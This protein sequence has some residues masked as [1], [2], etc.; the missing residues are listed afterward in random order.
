MKYPSLPAAGTG[1]DRAWILAG[2][3]LPASLR[4]LTVRQAALPSPEGAVMAAEVLRRSGR[5]DDAAATASRAAST[6]GLDPCDRALLL[7]AE[8]HAYWSL[9][10][11]QQARG[12]YLEAG[13]VSAGES[14]E[15]TVAARLGAARAGR[16]NLD[17]AAGRVA[18]DAL[19]VASAV[20]DPD[21]LADA[22]RENAA[23]ALMRG[24]APA[25]RSL[26][27][28]AARTH[29]RAGD[30]YLGGLARVLRARALSADGNTDAAVD[31]V[32]A[33]VAAGREVGAAELVMTASVY[34]GQFLQRAATP[35]SERWRE[36]VDVLLGALADAADPVTEAELLLPLAHLWIASGEWPAAR[37]A[38]GRYEALYEA[39]GGNAVADANAAKARARLRIAEGGELQYG[40]FRAARTLP[41]LIAGDRLLR[42]AERL[43]RRAR[44]PAGAGSVRQ[45]R[46]M[47]D[48]LAGSRRI[49]PLPK[50]T[51]I[52]PAGLA[53]E[54]GGA[55]ARARDE[56]L[57][58]SAL[59]ARGR[60]RDAATAF[61]ESQ[62]LALSADSTMLA[63]A[64]AARRAE[65]ASDAD[66]RDQ[67]RLGVRDAVRLTERVRG[68][69]GTGSARG[70]LAG[71]LRSHYERAALLAA[72]LGDGDL[73]LEV[74][75]ALRSERL[76]GLVRARAVP[77]D[78]S[79][80]NDVVAALAAVDEEFARRENFGGTLRNAA[81]PGLRG[82]ASPAPGDDAAPALAALDED[83]LAAERDRMRQRLADLT[84]EVFADL[85]DT[86][87]SPWD[88]L[89]G[90]LRC[91]VLSVAP[92][93]VDGSPPV[94]V[95]AWRAPDGASGVGV[96]EATGAVDRLRDR[97]RAAPP[98]SRAL[99]G[100]ADL[101]CL[102]GLVPPAL[103]LSVARSDGPVD[104]VVVPAG[105]TWAVPFCALPL[106]GAGS[107]IVDRCDVTLAASL[108]THAILQDRPDRPAATA[109]AVSYADPDD[110]DIDA[111]V[112]LA[113]L[114]ASPG[115][116]VPLDDP[117]AFRAA[118]STSGGRF[119]LAAAAAHGNLAPGL[120][121]AVVTRTGMAV[122]AAA[123]FLRPAADPPQ[124]LSFA[125]CHGM[126]PPWDD[127][128]E[129]L[130]LALCALSAG[131][132]AVLSGQY[133]VDGATGA[134]AA[135]LAGAY[136][137][138]LRGERPATALA[139]AQRE[140][141]RTLPLS[142][143][144]VLA[145]LGIAP[146]DTPVRTLLAEGA[147][148]GHAAT[149]S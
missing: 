145:V 130:G 22:Q 34:L 127:Q 128:Y 45:Q 13:L 132:E 87:R 129:P 102:A 49:G 76:A 17:A 137:G 109:A 16:I 74:L 110:P 7:L 80:L 53:A 35:D 120:S 14:D 81:V 29:D 30:R 55:L 64:A 96:V 118:A 60:N 20:G 143:W 117:A 79:G 3:D 147:D 28:A 142:R 103:A 134:A 43:Y 73:L 33:E 71:S 141:N 85:Y 52:D 108:R 131:A 58:G 83:D 139:R 148:G 112:E 50:G 27:E 2:S 114:D 146:N 67:A 25:A 37:N 107:I 94:I 40:G 23:W 46:D 144:A 84:S 88:D 68:A 44:L 135:V 8:G 65:A 10:R 32:R 124:V 12:R 42:R 69:V 82:P 93:A 51:S 101:R 47:L 70:R 41:V 133:E 1:D 48:A 15:W 31:A 119:R 57:R 92:L 140:V 19:A 98:A 99:L 77:L 6:D 9:G 59:H 89:A 21:L 75:E 125:V 105:W 90:D 56:F 26:A 100:A 138:I 36:G 63:V 126:F 106:D 54:A 136:E 91:H 111:E 86:A 5:P 78:T 24:D 4:L 95:S 39:A 62:R 122:V 97:L 38:I 61:A 116:H 115:G 123:D 18:A 121:Q 113:A 66:D 72:R 149:S 11:S 104:L